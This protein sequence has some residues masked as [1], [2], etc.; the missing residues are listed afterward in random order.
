M[1][2][3]RCTN[4]EATQGALIKTTEVNKEEFEKNFSRQFR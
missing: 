3:K 1:D 4:T 2:L